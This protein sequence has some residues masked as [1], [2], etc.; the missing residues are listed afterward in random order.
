MISKEPIKSVSDAARY[1]DKSFNKDAGQK[2]DNYYIN[3]KATA[4]W[5]GRGAEILGI[6]G[7]AVEKKDFV[8]FLS[9]KLVNPETGEVIDLAK[10]SKGESRRPGIDFTVAPPKSVSIAG[11]VGKDDRIVAAHLVANERT[12]QWFEKHASIIRV[13]DENGR[14]RPERAGNLLYASVLHET[15]RENEPQ[16]HSHNV[17]VSAVYDEKR[18]VWRSLT[19]DM[20][21]NLRAQGDV[22]YKAELAGALKTL[23]YELEYAT[24]GVDFEIKGFTREHVDTYSTRSTQVREALLKRGIDPGE[25]SFD[26]R[27]IAKLDSR[28]AKQEHPREVLQDIW[29]ETARRAGLDVEAIVRAAQERSPSLSREDG[30]GMVRPGTTIGG[31]GKDRSA[32]PQ[33]SG[34]VEPLDARRA[35]GGV[36]NETEP[37]ADAMRAVS[38]AIEHLTEREQSFELVDLEIAAVRFSRGMIDDVD[39]AVRRHIENHMLVERG[40]ND[41][42]RL[43][44]TTHR[45]IDSE[46]RL[47]ET[48]QSGVASGN[49]ILHDASEFET[50]LKAFEQKREQETGKPFRLSDEQINA[51]R[52]VLMHPDSFQGIQGEA[53]T[54]KTAA[55]AMVNDVALARGWNVI[56]VATSAAAATEL[57]S[58][59]GMKSST[60]AA[61]FAAR[62][63][64]VRTIEARIAELRDA[65]DRRENIR[66]TDAARMESRRLRVT[67]RDIDFGTSRYSFDHQRGEVFK[68]PDNLR[69]AIGA[70]LTEVAARHRS[71]SSGA[72]QEGETFAARMRTGAVDLAG[73]LGRRLSTFEQVGTV[74]AIAARNALYGAR[75]GPGG[76][77]QRE[78]LVRQSELANLRRYGNVEGRKTLIVMDES[79]LTGAFDTEKIARLA[80]E[81][82]ARVVF[83]GDIKQH[84]SV[85]AGRAFE[86]AQ[87]AGMN[88]SVLEETRRFV[89]ASAPTRQ[90]MLEMKAGNYG[91]AVAMLDTVSV[92]SGELAEAVAERYLENLEALHARGVQNPKIGVVAI[93]NR[94]RKAINEAIHVKLAGK[95]L[96]SDEAFQKPH[97]DDP[98][99]TG[100]EQ[101]YAVM[102]R[103]KKVDALV[104]RKTYREIGVEKGDVLRVKSYD[105]DRNRIYAVNASGKTV[106][107]NPQR[108][109]YFS[110]AVLEG[111]S[112][113]A[114]DRIE[115]RAIIRLPDQ[116]LQRV[117]NGTPG[118]ITAID[119]RGA[120]IRWTRTGKESYLGNDDIRFVDH[121]Y[122]HT[123]YKEQGATNDREIIAVSVTGAKVFNREAAYVAASRARDNTEIV[124]EDRESMLRTAGKEVGKTTAVE[125]ERPP[126]GMPAPRNGTTGPTQ[127]NTQSRLATEEQARKVD[128]GARPAREPDA[129]QPGQEQ[130]RRLEI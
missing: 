1:H 50:A 4:R 75:P 61:F 22:I 33:A 95:G 84:G 90:A 101:R 39:A 89:D 42:G 24:N 55:L 5:E 88:V 56:G 28:A 54:G 20:L 106:E 107:I 21:H 120:R 23:G 109:D 82:G 18:K 111:R 110:P 104:Y 47:A 29:Q 68:S 44:Y 41:A 17:I 38:W 52:N 62:D 2:A 19:N 36:G 49:T 91:R 86:Q 122:A 126:R 113:S 31:D 12:M 63:T 64:Q 108:Q 118:V 27:R 14:N 8:N 48:I 103:E 59:S 46:M 60:V 97:L 127:A 99:L 128:G 81:I 58:S 3:E 116:E 71:P 119:E 121:A 77:L 15:N 83:Q 30:A 115:T 7:K 102:L 69:N 98:K 32:G 73:A 9:G 67:G 123:S 76:D 40:I 79:S 130:G 87:N 93:T 78:L 13:K 112:F 125:F 11:L 35:P 105:V 53:G 129:R 10:N 57:E 45:A 94:D 117:D 25:A 16:I 72:R 80:R 43:L 70:A 124:T 114:G 26:A 66:D 51:A 85:A 96:V 65:L 34:G 6:R 74:E 100:A 37:G 92:E